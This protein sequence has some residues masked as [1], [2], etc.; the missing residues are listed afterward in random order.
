[1]AAGYTLRELMEYMGQSSLRATERYVQLLPVARRA[2]R[3]RGPAQ[4]LSGCP[5]GRPMIRS[6]NT[7]LESAN[8]CRHRSGSSRFVAATAGPQST[9]S[10]DSF[11]GFGCRRRDSNPRHADYD[12]RHGGA[13]RSEIPILRAFGSPDMPSDV[14]S[15]VPFPSDPRC[16]LTQDASTGTAHRDLRAAAA[17]GA[18]PSSA[19]GLGPSAPGRPQVRR[20]LGR[21]LA[22][23]VGSSAQACARAGV[24]GAGETR[25][26]LP[27]QAGRTATARRAARRV[28]P[29]RRRTTRRSPT[30]RPSGCATSSSIASAVRRRCATTDTSA[31]ATCCRSSASCRC[32]R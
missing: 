15:S 17:D 26:R 25:V 7:D 3:C 32:G 27:D 19:A 23:R 28:A 5:Q 21:A 16:S 30:L 6:A 24:D 10:R 20:P 1:M 8:I 13:T 18:R 12:R 22:R 9:R 31:T 11:G 29:Q 14:L 4:R 2:P